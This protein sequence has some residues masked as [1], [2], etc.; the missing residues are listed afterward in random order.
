MKRSTERK[1]TVYAS[2][3][4]AEIVNH[5]MEL[6]VSSVVIAQAIQNATSRVGEMFPES[7]I[8][9][10]MGISLESIHADK[11]R[12]GLAGTRVDRLPSDM[13]F[14][15]QLLA[16]AEDVED[17][18]FRN[19]YEIRG[20]VLGTV[21]GALVLSLDVQG[22]LTM[23]VALEREA[24]FVPASC[25]G[26]QGLM[27]LI[28]SQAPDKSILNWSSNGAIDRA[29][30]LLARVLHDIAERRAGLPT[31][32]MEFIRVL[33]FRQAEVL[34]FRSMFLPTED[35]VREFWAIVSEALF[36]YPQCLNVLTHLYR[37]AYCMPTQLALELGMSRAR[38]Y[39]IR[40]EALGVLCR[41][42][43]HAHLKALASPEEARRQHRALERRS[44]VLEG[45]LADLVEHDVSCTLTHRLQE[46]LRPKFL[47][48]GSILP[49]RRSYSIPFILARLKV[50]TIADLVFDVSLERAFATAGLGEFKVR[51]LDDQLRDYC[52]LGIGEATKRGWTRE[53]FGLALKE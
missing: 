47:Q 27:A 52:G 33:R 34:G 32:R 53:E 1:K 44:E 2:D 12:M 20:L 51:Y 5:C 45:A 15:V 36:A 46:A 39:Q 4:R 40:D 43:W 17:F 19:D 6:G 14:P 9:R 30:E 48:S 23:L 38:L 42:P 10:G 18:G 26:T 16:L 28:C 22:I 37:G 29:R 11:T 13:R 24:T 41:A 21:H 8:S 7:Y 35:D 31:T 25:R 49:S 3:V 50:S